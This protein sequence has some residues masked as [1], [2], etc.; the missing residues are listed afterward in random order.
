MGRLPNLPPS[1]LAQEEKPHSD[2]GKAHISMY[3][4]IYIHVILYILYIYDMIRYM[5]YDKIY[6]NIQYI[7]IYHNHLFYTVC[8]TVQ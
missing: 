8:I 5:I 2:L 7:Y 6:D 3:I 1:S 4:Y